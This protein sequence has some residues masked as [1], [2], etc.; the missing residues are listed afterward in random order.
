[1]V[2]ESFCVGKETTSEVLDQLKITIQ[3]QMFGCLATVY[4]RPDPWDQ[5]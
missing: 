5:I 3:L 2:M 4:A 1:M